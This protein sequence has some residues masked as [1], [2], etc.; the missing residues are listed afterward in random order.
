M[1]HQQQELLFIKFQIYTSFFNI[2]LL[3]TDNLAIM[4]VLFPS[5]PVGHQSERGKRQRGQQKALHAAHEHKQ[6]EA[7]GIQT[8]MNPE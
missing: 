4:G 3:R 7:F 8:L 5:R 1:I 2:I 6:R